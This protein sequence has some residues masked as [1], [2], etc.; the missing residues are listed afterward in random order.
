MTK[1]RIFV[2]RALEAFSENNRNSIKVITMLEYL[3]GNSK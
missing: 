1:K 3:K 2:A